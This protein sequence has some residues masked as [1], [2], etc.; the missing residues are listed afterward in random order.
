MLEIVETLIGMCSAVML[1][2]GGVLM[3]SGLGIADIIYQIFH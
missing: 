2:L 1:G 3:A